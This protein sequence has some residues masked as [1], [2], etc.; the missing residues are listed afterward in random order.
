MWLQKK[1]QAP[2]IGNRAFKGEKFIQQFSQHFMPR[3]GHKVRYYGFYAFGAKKL[4]AEI[5][6]KLIGSPPSN[7]EKPSKKELIKKMLGQDLD[8]CTSCGV[9]NSLKT[10]IILA[11]PSLIYSLTKR[12]SHLV[13]LVPCRKSP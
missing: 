13:E 6:Q 8:L 7:Y 2:L 1:G 5:H 12:Q 11:T 3:G 10:E 9:Y 4:K